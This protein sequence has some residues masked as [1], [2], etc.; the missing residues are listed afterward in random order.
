M[1]NTKY[2]F[3]SF[4]L[5]IQTLFAMEAPRISQIDLDQK[6][7]VHFKEIVREYYERVNLAKAK[8]GTPEGLKLL[9]NGYW[10]PNDYFEL[11]SLNGSAGA[12]RLQ[13]LKDNNR[14]VDGYSSVATLEFDR[15][16]KLSYRLKA[17]VSAKDA[18]TQFNKGIIF[19]DCTIA[20]QLA[21]YRTALEVLGDIK[22]EKYFGAS[23]TRLL[24]SAEIM[25]SKLS[26]LLP[27]VPLSAKPGH[28]GSYYYVKNHPG[29]QFKNR[30]GDERGFN[31]L[32]LSPHE[33]PEQSLFIAFGLDPAGFTLS[34]IKARLV[35]AFNKEALNERIVSTALWNAR[36]LNDINEIVAEFF[37][38]RSI[39]STTDRSMEGDLKH[40]L[41][42]FEKADELFDYIWSNMWN[43]KGLIAQ[44]SLDASK[45]NDLL[46]TH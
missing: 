36:Q 9:E 29:Y 18:V 40:L 24:F 16:N 11:L 33:D 10:Y 32:V 6:I 20:C 25:N 38:K 35:A 41:S 19:F 45:L 21:Y 44:I 12:N 14:F 42:R 43:P 46:L 30:Y 5:S 15:L 22:F 17:N 13:W 34:Q 3:L 1:K 28:A 37:L 26:T 8:A 7:L 31:L 23:N 27:N 4:I 39:S 2:L